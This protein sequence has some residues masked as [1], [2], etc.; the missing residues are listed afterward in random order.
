[1][2]TESPIKR[3]WIEAVVTRADGRVE[4][5]GTVSDSRAWFNFGP[6]RILARRRIK[7]ANR[8]VAA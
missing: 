5:L 2:K 8:G 7:K 3:S 6:G 4:N 1:M